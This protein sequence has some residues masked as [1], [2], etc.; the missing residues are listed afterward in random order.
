MR[1]PNKLEQKRLNA[2]VKRTEDAVK[3][4][5]KA[6][7]AVEDARADLAAIQAE[8]MKVGNSVRKATGVP[9]GTLFVSEMECKWATP[10][11]K[12]LLLPANAPAAPA[13]EKKVTAAEKARRVRKVRHRKSRK[14]G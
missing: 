1:N 13:K 10:D 14:K 7:E 12:G 9:P 11:G 4:F 2:V 8:A 5:N 3:K 6:G